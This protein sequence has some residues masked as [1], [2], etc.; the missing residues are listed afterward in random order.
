M[1]EDL[2]IE[3]HE[4]LQISIPQSVSPQSLINPNHSARVQDIVEEDLRLRAGEFGVWS[5]LDDEGND[6]DH[7]VIRRPKEGNL[8]TFQ[9]THLIAVSIY[10]SRDMKEPPPNQS[11][12]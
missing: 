8:V 6:V 2:W 4:A 1:E 9:S 12:L 5:R 7:L 11:Q 10:S 3:Q